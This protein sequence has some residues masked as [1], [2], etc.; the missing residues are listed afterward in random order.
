M[1]TPVLALAAV[2]HHPAPVRPTGEH[3]HLI[4]QLVARAP[5]LSEA[6]RAR[7]AAA[8][9]SMSKAAA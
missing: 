9:G 8:L 1:A 3:D 5:Q 2:P 7:I 4:A 6:R